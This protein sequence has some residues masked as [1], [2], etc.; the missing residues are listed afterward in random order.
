MTQLRSKPGRTKSLARLAAAVAICSIAQAAWPQPVQAKSQR[1]VFYTFEQVWPAAIRFLRVDEGFDIVERD[2]EAGYVLFAV[3][4][5][6]KR[7]RGALE[8]VRIK[9]ENGRQALRL[10]LRVEDRPS[11]TEISILKRLERKLRYELGEP[12]EPAPKPKDQDKSKDQSKA[13]NQATG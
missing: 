7:F 6:N 9:D 8:L 3:N 12:A 10:V 5:E 11:Y 2:A 13:S 1:V 4:E